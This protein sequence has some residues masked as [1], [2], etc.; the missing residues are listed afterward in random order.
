MSTGS[1]KLDALKQ[2]AEA[3]DPRKLSGIN[4]YSRFAFAGALCCSVTHGALT[5]VDVVKTRIQLDPVTY[6]RGLIG[7]FRQVV[8]NE[9]AGALLTGAGPTFAGYFL[10]GAFKFGGYEFFKQQ[11]IYL[12][13]YETA[14]QNRTAVYLASSALAEF[15]ADIALCPLEATRI[16]LVSEPTFATGL[17]S[18][19]SKIAKTEGLGAFYSGFGPILFK[20]VPYTMAKFV[21]Y[22]KVSEYIYTNLVDRSKTSNGMNTAINLGSGLIAGFAAAI[23]SQP[24]DTM[25]SKI[26]KTKGLPG[27][28]TTSRLIKIAKELGLRGSYA[29]IGARLFMVGTLTA[30]QFAIYGDTKRIMGAVGGVEIAK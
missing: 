29:G 15:F 12:L 18:G 19:F 4:L 9:G 30:G 27:E 5:P 10:Q 21:V 6:N 22:E 17:V 20:Q 26:N 28:G 16:R 11:S 13:G 8:A 1:A 25:L 23:V 3:K 24:A 14:S 2:V 7:G